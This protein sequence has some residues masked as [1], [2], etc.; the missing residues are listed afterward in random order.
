MLVDTHA[1]L[2]VEQFKDDRDE[3]V[4]RAFAEGVTKLYLPNIDSSSIDG[5]FALEKKYPDNCFAMMGLHPCSVKDNY[6]EELAIAERWLSER[7][8]CA[9]GEMGTDLY[10]DKTH[11][12]EQQEAFRIQA[13]WAKELGIPIVI[14]CRETIDETIALVQEAQDGR[15]RGIFHCFGGSVE[16]AKAMIDLGFYLGIGGVL[17]FK[18][19]NL[20]EVLQE[21]SLEHLVLE[22]DSPYLSPVP[23]RG[24]RN[25]SAYLKPIA[26]KLAEVKETSLEEVARITT[27]NAAAIFG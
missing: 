13:G 23:F 5:M 17:T 24:K 19:T 6:K 14:H 25:E 4:Q 7:S 9:V 18:K 20:R 12:K 8:F 10:W 11:W 15:L 2:Y 22:T 27:Q 21:I 16:Q 3:M 26:E 1:H